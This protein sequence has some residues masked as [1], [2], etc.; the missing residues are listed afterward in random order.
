MDP[1]N[2][3][4]L[5]ATTTKVVAHWNPR[6]KEAL[7]YLTPAEV[8]TSTLVEA[9]SGGMIEFLA[10]DPLRIAEPNLNVAIVLT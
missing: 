9:A 1:V 10:S 5:L 3:R 4:Q 8:F 7:G 2:E 6:I